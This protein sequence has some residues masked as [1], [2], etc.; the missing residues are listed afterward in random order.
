[1]SIT[2][3]SFYKHLSVESVDLLLFLT[4]DQALNSGF[5]TRNHKR[6]TTG[7]KKH[8]KNGSLFNLE[9]YILHDSTSN[10]RIFNNILFITVL[11]LNFCPILSCFYDTSVPFLLS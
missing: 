8:I 3:L 7:T 11:Y 10:L 2:D 9:L 5:G 1:M 6:S 4:F